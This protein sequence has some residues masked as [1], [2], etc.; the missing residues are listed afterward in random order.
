MYL[1]LGA[2][3]FL[4]S[5][6]LDKILSQ[7]EDSVI[8]VTRKEGFIKSSDRVIPFPCDIGRFEQIDAL[9]DRIKTY[10]KCKVIDL[11]FWHNLDTLAKNEAEAWHT[12]ITSLSYFLHAIDD[13]ECFFFASTD[14]VYG[15]GEENRAFC[16]E[17]ELE[18]ISRY[19]VHKAAAECLVSARGGS[20]F[21]LPYMFGPS[22]AVGKKHFYD[23]ILENL[24]SDKPTELFD[25]QYRSSLDFDKVASLFVYMAENH[26][27]LELPPVLNLCGDLSLS[28]Y[29]L[30]L[31]LAEKY[32]LPKDLLLPVSAATFKT[33]PKAA[34]AFNGAMDNSKLKELLGLDELK[35]KL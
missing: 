22:K 20:S 5:Y 30:G 13:F 7:T 2:N 11:A 6:I 3:G 32:D 26:A 10:G 24:K 35:I 16:E 1:L 23:I 18:P 33:D 21:R 14:C 8:A 9:A 28:K 17:D 12:N 29:D 15:E 34:R 27:S 31:L 19:G 25:D 4:G